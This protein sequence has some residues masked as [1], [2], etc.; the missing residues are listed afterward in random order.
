VDNDPESL[1]AAIRSISTMRLQSMGLKGRQWMQAE[2]SWQSVTR[3]MLA[4]YQRCA[5]R[6]QVHECS[7]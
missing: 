6:D 1:A 2:F 7:G 4:L 3:Q 5:R